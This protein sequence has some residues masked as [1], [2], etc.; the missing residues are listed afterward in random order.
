MPMH[1]IGRT[2]Y[3]IAFPD[4]LPGLAFY[5]VVAHAIGNEQHLP[6]RMNVPVTSGTRLKIDVADQGIVRT[7]IGNQTVGPCLTGEVLGRS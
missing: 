3:Y 5:L 6:G 2:L 4:R 7:I 1:D